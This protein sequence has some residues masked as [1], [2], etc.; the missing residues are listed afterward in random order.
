VKEGLEHGFKKESIEGSII[1]ILS[2]EDQVR[3]DTLKECQFYPKS[4]IIS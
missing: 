1:E 2:A 3:K 4:L